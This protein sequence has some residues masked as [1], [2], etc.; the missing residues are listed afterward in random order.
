M[1]WV[2]VDELDAEDLS[3]REG[4]LYL[5]GEVWRRGLRIDW[6]LLSNVSKVSLAALSSS[7][8]ELLRGV[9]NAIDSPQQQQKRQWRAEQ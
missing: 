7:S 6:L 2:V 3:V 4:G 9:E 5:D 8:S 1:G